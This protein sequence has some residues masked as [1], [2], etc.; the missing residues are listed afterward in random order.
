M[1]RRRFSVRRALLGLA[2]VLAALA[3]VW[4]AGLHLPA[5][6]V[7]GP[8]V[9]GETRVFGYATLMNPLVRLYVI[10]RPTPSQPAA[11]EG[12]RRSGRDLVAEPGAVVEGRAF[13]VD[14]TGMRRL[15]RYERIGSVYERDLKTLR[16]GRRAWVYRMIEPPDR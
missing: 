2:V 8:A 7:E 4:R 12:F 11:L 16:D 9:A 3:A 6:V 10:G 13:T 5:P 1:S 14:A 15:D